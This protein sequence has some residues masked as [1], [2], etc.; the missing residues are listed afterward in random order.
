MAIINFH[1]ARY[2]NTFGPHPPARDL[3]PGDTLITGILDTYGQ[4]SAGHKIAPRPNPLVGPFNII[5]AVPGDTLVVKINQI[6]PTRSWGMSYRSLR[7]TVVPAAM[8]PELPPR[9]IVRWTVDA[10]NG[11]VYP[12]D[13]PAGLKNLRIPMQPMLGCIG[14]APPLNQFISSYTCGNYGGN[15]D[16]PRVT[17]ASTLYLPVFVEGALLFFTDGH[18][19]QAHG[20]IAGMGIE[21]SMQVEMEIGLIPGKSIAMPRGE[22]DQLRYTFGIDRPLE[23]A[24]QNA[25]GEM[26]SWLKDDPGLTVGDACQLLGQTA[27]YGMGNIISPNYAVTCEVEKTLLA[28]A[29]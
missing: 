15:M 12:E 27:R 21:V 9:E 28:T 22:N 6:L 16:S 19:V 5:G 7:P 11:V 2:Y 18:A 17:A 20:E 8:V 4:D 14:V 24:I 13:P 29:S 1:P 3:H 23:S 26:I 10:G 25:T